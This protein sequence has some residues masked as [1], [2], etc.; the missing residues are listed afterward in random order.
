MPDIYSLVEN[1]RFTRRSEY[2]MKPPFK[3]TNMGQSSISYVGP[4]VWNNLPSECRL[5]INSN[6]F[7][8]KIKEHFFENIQRVNDDIYLYY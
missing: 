1:P 7:K 5:E 2:R 4:K 3:L 8:H 6:K